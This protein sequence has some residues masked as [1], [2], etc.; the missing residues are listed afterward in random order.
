MIYIEIAL[1]SSLILFL[2]FVIPGVREYLTDGRN[3]KINIA[4][5]FLILTLELCLTINLFIT[6]VTYFSIIVWVIT[7]PVLVVCAVT[8]SRCYKQVR[9]VINFLN[10]KPE[11]KSLADELFKGYIFFQ[12]GMPGRGTSKEKSDYEKAIKAFTNL[13]LE[14]E[15]ADIRFLQKKFR[16]NF[17]L[18]T[19]LM[20]LVI[21]WFLQI[22]VL[23]SLALFI[24]K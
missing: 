6:D 3:Q 4:S 17:L 8:K 11:Y 19:L 13:N 10:T 15:D 20:D 23:V 21:Y 24:S 7:I 2:S 14:Y 9:S 12:G 18:K 5:V 1:M 16:I 22:F